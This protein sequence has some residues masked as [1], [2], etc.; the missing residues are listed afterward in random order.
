MPTG[1]APTI[2]TRELAFCSVILRCHSCDGFDARTHAVRPTDILP[3]QSGM[4]FAKN[5]PLLGLDSQLADE[6]APQLGIRRDDPG[7]VR[8]RIDQRLGAQPR[9]A[10]E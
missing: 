9:E 5:V 1:P 7:E 6:I 10:L 3:D 2:T 4:L 8:R